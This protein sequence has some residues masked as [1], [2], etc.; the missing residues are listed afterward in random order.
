MQS[1]INGSVLNIKRYPPLLLRRLSKTLCIKITRSACLKCRWQG[2]IP[3]NS[4]SI[5]LPWVLEFAVLI[6]TQVIL[7][8]VIGKLHFEKHALI[9]AT[10]EIKAFKIPQCLVPRLNLSYSVYSFLIHNSPHLY[11]TLN[12]AV[13]W[14]L[15]SSPV[16]ATFC[17]SLKNSF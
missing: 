1:C 13:G 14:D 2:V 7:K 9:C 17:N 3:Q 10:E 15:H 6:S 5:V 12:Q 11:L 16:K 8:Y 4:I